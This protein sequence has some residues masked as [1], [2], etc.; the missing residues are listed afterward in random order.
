MDND[1]FWNRQL[2]ILLAMLLLW[3]VAVGAYRVLIIW[4]P[5]LCDSMWGGM[6]MDKACEWRGDEN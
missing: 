2:T 6:A 1:K 3:P 4:H 5:E